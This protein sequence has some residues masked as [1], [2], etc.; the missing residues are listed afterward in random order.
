MGVTT[1][2]DDTTHRAESLTAFGSA[3]TATIST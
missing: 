2:T 3:A 1:L